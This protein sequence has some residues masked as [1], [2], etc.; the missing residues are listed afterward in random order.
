MSANWSVEVWGEF[1]MIVHKHIHHFPTPAIGISIKEL[2]EVLVEAENFHAEE[3]RRA[4][5]APWHRA[6]CEVGGA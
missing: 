1:V 5:E 3:A 6:L 4:E 2:R